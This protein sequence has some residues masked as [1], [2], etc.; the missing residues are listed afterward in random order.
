MDEL[1]KRLARG[2]HAAFAELYDACAG[3]CH[4]YLTVYLGSA[5]A[6][7]E[8]LQETFMRLVRNRGKLSRV[9]NLPAYVFTVARNEAARYAGRQARDNRRR[10][11]LAAHDLFV[12]GRGDEAARET[13]DLVAAALMRLAGEQREVV[14]LKVYGG[15][16]FREIGDITGVP[17]ATAATR[18]RTA[19]ARLKDWLARQPS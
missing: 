10:T 8:V 15:F 13:A 1:G 14:E 4:H 6:A 9:E 3:R 5:D 18:Y 2:E 11:A 7:D 17:A 16:T 12:E 19:L